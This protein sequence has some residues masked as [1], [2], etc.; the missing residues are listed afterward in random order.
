MIRSDEDPRRQG[1]HGPA[2]A[3]M[4]D[5]DRLSPVTVALVTRAAEGGHWMG[6]CRARRPG[7]RFAD[8]DRDGRGPGPTGRRG[9]VLRLASDGRTSQV[10]VPLWQFSDSESDSNAAGTRAAVAC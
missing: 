1:G 10:L 8:R 3:D 2:A 4:S 9:A 6:P 7:L 5:R